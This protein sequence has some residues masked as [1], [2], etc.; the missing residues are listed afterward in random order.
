MSVSTSPAE[1]AKLHAHAVEGYP[2]EVVGI[3]AGDR[4][5]RRIERVHPLINERSDSAHN[6]Y[7]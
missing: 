6:R 7:R 3:L 2:H 5:T 4:A 1:L